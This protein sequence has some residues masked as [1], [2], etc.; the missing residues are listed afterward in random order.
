LGLA[1]LTPVAAVAVTATAL[2]GLSDFADLGWC[3]L[4]FDGRRY[5]AALELLGRALPPRPFT[6][7][8]AA[9]A[10][11]AGDRCHP[12]AGGLHGRQ[13]GRCQL[14]LTDFSVRDW[15]D[16]LGAIATPPSSRAAPRSRLTYLSPAI[17]CSESASDQCR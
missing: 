8:A 3:V 2:A 13:V 6:A 5:F 12:V 16:P 15:S 17:Q 7:L 14:L 10:I 11:G 9:F 1:T 4:S